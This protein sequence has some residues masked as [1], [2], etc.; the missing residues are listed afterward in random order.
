MTTIQRCTACNARLVYLA[1]VRTGKIAPIEVDP[2]E[3]GNIVFD[4]DGRYRMLKK[5]EETTRARR[6]NHFSTCPDANRFHK[7]A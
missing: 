6:K 1:H 5:G 2:S 3:D 7:G 4:T